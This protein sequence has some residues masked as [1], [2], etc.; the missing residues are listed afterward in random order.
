MA[1]IPLPALD[2]RPPQ[3]QPSP[4]EQYGQLM[5]IRNAQ[6]EQQMRQQQMQTGAIQQQG[7]QVQLQQQQQAL[8]DQKA[9]TAAMQNW[10]GKDYNDILP[11][12]IKNGGSANAVIGLKS[13]ILEQQQSISTA[14]KNNADAASAQMTAVKTKGDLLD[15]T[16]STLI[17]PKQTPDAQL[18]QAVISAAQ[19]L[20]QKGVLDPAH[21]QQA[22]QFAQSGNPA[23]IRQQLDLM[24]KTNLAQSQ[25][26]EDAQKQAL[27][28]EANANTQK[29]QQELQFGPTGPAAEGKY[30]FILGRIQNGSATPADVAWA[31]SYEDAQTK[32]TSTSDSLGVVSSNTSKPAGVA[33]ASRATGAAQGGNRP[34]TTSSLPSSGSGNPASVKQGIVDEIGQYRMDPTMLGRMLYKH[35]EMLGLIHEKYPDWDQT[36]YGAKNKMVQSYTSG[37]ESRSINAIGTALGH[38]SEMRDA[39]DALGNVNVNI[40]N[41]IAN[42][43]GAQVGTTPATTF[44]MI[45]HRLSPEITAAYVQGGGGEGERVSNAEDFSSSMS[46]QQLK[47]NWSETMKLL[48]SKIA[49][50]KQQWDTTYR[51]TTP[52]DDFYTRFMSPVAKQA[53]SRWSNETGNKGAMNGSSNSNPN[54]PVKITTSSGGTIVI[55]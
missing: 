51:P 41:T 19:D 44:N 48:Q 49:Q 27:T 50:Q 18:P 54:S 22:E 52:Q 16:L 10:D 55:E 35:P 32:Q 4:L 5:A 17:D 2:V 21:A 37:P 39:I 34:L 42:K 25:I 7:A 38:A 24:R 43:I 14:L 9:M 53:I 47:N 20:A 29:T 3:Q 8:S 40:L 26:L 30:R 33:T 13:K 23:Q 46:P 6:Q 12:V 36:E 1:T 11:L 31:K 28:N 45:V 15:G